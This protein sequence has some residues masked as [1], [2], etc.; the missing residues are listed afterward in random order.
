MDSLSLQTFGST[1]TT[2]TSLSQ[3][4][5]RLSWRLVRSLELST[6]F[7]STLEDTTPFFDSSEHSPPKVNGTHVPHFDAKGQANAFFPADKSTILY[8][9]FLLGEL[10]PVWLGQGRGRPQ[11]SRSQQQQPVAR[12]CCLY[13]IGNVHQWHFQGW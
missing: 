2:T 1:L 10:V 3:L 7:W 4:K 9:S 13:D 11:Q 8:T 12:D 6:L 5:Q